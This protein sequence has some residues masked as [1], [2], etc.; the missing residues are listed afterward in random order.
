MAA[1]K[2]TT[3]NLMKKLETLD[4]RNL[5]E[6]ME[7]ILRAKDMLDETPPRLLPN[8]KEYLEFLYDHVSKCY[9]EA[10]KLFSDRDPERQ[11]RL[12][13]GLHVSGTDY[14]DD[15][16]RTAYQPYVDNM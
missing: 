1:A 7:V 13:Y 3:E 4:K 12:F 8:K 2:V 11:I 5:K 14:L 9:V 10:L 15:I 16:I 6:M